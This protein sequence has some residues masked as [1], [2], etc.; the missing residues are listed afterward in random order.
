MGWPQGGV[1]TQA[2]TDAVVKLLHGGP[3]EHLLPAFGGFLPKRDRAAYAQRIAY[4]LRAI[5]ITATISACA[6]D[7]YHS[8]NQCMRHTTVS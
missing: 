8:N 5:G 1:T 3:A 6:V 4:V 7:W 2:L